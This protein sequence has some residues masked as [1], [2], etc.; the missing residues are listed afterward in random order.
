MLISLCYI[1][2]HI[3]NILMNKRLP[4]QQ[5]QPI[6]VKIEFPPILVAR[7][8]ILHMSNFVSI[9]LHQNIANTLFAT[10]GVIERSVIIL[11]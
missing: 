7:Q 4:L 3:L 6:F 9:T 11:F 2:M 8:R 5:H 10:I 1:A